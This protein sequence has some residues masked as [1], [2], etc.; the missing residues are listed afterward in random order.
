MIAIIAARRAR[1]RARPTP[2]K[3]PGLLAKVKAFFTP[4]NNTSKG[5]SS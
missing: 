5:R 2:K 4:T 3:G 1:E